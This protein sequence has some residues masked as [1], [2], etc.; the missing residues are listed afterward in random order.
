MNYVTSKNVPIS[1]LACSRIKYRLHRQ[2]CVSLAKK[3]PSICRLHLHLVLFFALYNGNCPR[4]E[5]DT[6]LKVKIYVPR[7]LHN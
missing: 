3:F 6:Q 4:H 2:G 5:K 1:F 7:L